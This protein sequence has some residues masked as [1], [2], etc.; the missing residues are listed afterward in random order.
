MTPCTVCARI[1][2]DGKPRERPAAYTWLFPAGNRELL[3]E[4][5]CACWR[6]NATE[7]PDLG[8]LRITTLAA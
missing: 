7:D 1:Y 4:S 6:L 8:A 3:C 2:R 5:C